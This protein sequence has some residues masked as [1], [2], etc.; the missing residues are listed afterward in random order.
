ME[1]L[2]RELFWESPLT[3]RDDACKLIEET[4]DSFLGRGGYLRRELGR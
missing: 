2:M 4:L 3:W 1:S